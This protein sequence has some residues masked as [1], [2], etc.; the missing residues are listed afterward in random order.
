M[1]LAM[2]VAILASQNTFDKT[3]RYNKD[4][5]TILES[6]TTGG[7]LEIPLKEKSEPYGMCF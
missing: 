2:Y 4:V 3:S 7:G 1:Y 6:G 5:S